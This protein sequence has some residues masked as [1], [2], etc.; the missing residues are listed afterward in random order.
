MQVICDDYLGKIDKLQKEL[1]YV[2]GEQK[3]DKAELKKANRFHK[4]QNLIETGLKGFQQETKNIH[5]Q[6][7]AITTLNDHQDANHELSL[8]KMENKQFQ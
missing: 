7:K 4:V 5:N 3:E 1:D 8:M 6:F 2:R